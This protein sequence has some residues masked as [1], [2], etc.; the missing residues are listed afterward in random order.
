MF[1]LSTHLEYYIPSNK[2]LIFILTITVLGFPLVPMQGQV[3]IQSKPCADSWPNIIARCKGFAH[4]D[5]GNRYSLITGTAM[6]FKLCPGWIVWNHARV[7]PKIL[8]SALG[9][10]ATSNLLSMTNLRAAVTMTA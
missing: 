5:N 2:V 3:I 8:F 10:D 6:S 9:T 7:Y 1:K 4:C